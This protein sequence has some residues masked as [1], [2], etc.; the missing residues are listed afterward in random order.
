[1]SFDPENIWQLIKNFF[2]PKLNRMFFLRLGIIIVLAVV[3]FKFLLVPCV[4]SG[5]SMEPTVNSNGFTFCW[6]GRYWFSEPQRGDIVIIKYYNNI[7]FLKRIVGLPGETIEFKNGKL[8]INGKEYSEPYVKYPSDW[9][10]EPITVG[11]N[12]F[13]A[14]GDNRSM[15]IA[16]HQ[17]GAVRRQRII[18]SPLF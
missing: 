15:H 8:L 16:Q 1:M 12:E 6:L 7:F 9:E 13:Y 3:V 2:L 11:E 5:A 4:I 14:V 18:G 17:K 10:M